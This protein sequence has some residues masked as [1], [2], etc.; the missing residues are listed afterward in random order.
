MEEDIIRNYKQLQHPTAFGGQTLVHNFYRGIGAKKH[1]IENAL[2]HIDSYT[3]HREAKR[4]RVYN[5]FFIRSKREMIQ[6]D[7]MFFRDFAID[8]DNVSTFLTSI[9]S[10]S[11]YVWIEPV[12]STSHVHVNPAFERILAKMRK[13]TSILCDKGVEFEN[14]WF[15]Q[16]L[17]RH[18]IK[19][20]H[21][22]HR[23][24]AIERWHRTFKQI[25]AKFMAENETRRY[26]DHLQQIVDSYNQRFHRT[27]GMTPEQ[28]EKVKNAYIVNLNLQKYFN[29]AMQKT[30]KP[31]FKPGQEVR[32]QL[33]EDFR[34][35]RA[36]HQTFGDEIFKIKSVASKALPIPMYKLT[37]YDGSITMKDS[38]YETMLQ[39]VRRKNQEFRIQKVIRSRSMKGQKE[40]LVRWVGFGPEH[41]SWVPHKDITQVFNQMKK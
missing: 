25:C 10:F 26:I 27:I 3:K 28:A 12:Q 9:D 19:L 40:H 21:P 15:K 32:V 4:P 31:K 29:K 37:N 14:Q 33:R 13:C 30:R 11:R 39:P 36:H 5:P 38:Y 20:V 17:R 41:D 18:S 7:I 22:R 23:A 8:N 6:I 35:R 34:F 16:L 2:S 1:H 24:P